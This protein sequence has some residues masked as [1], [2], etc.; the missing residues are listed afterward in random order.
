MRFGDIA[1]DGA[2]GAI[3]AH[4]LKAEGLR[5]KKGRV[6]SAEDVEA[7]RA[8]GVAYVTAAVLEPGDVAENAAA[9]RLGAAVARDGV[10]VSEA[11]TGRVNLFAARNG[12]F[13][14]DRA[15][16]DR[17]NRIHPAITFACLND[18]VQV[19]EGTMVATIKII[20]LAVAGAAVDAAL[21]AI[22]EPGLI[23]VKPFRAMRTALVSTTLPTLKASVMDKTVELLRQRLAPS[24]S[25]LTGEW[26]VP[27]ETE[28]VSEALGEA[29]RGSDMLIL[30]GASAVVDPDDVIPAAIRAAGGVVHQVG[31]P[32]DPGNLLVIGALRGLP[33]IG[34]PGCARSPKENGFDWVLA[35]VLAGEVPGAR[36]IMAMGVGG[37]LTEIPSRPQPRAG[38]KNGGNRPVETVLLAAGRAS[39]M[40]EDSGHKLLALFDGEPLVRRA[41]RAA[42]EAGVGRVHAVV[43]FR[44]EAITEALAGL[45]LDIVENPDFETGMAGSLAAGVEC[46][47]HEAAGALV[48]L[49]DMPGLSAGH[50]RKLAAAFRARH[51]RAIVRAA[52][53]GRRGNPVILPREAFAQVLKLS[54]DLGARAI[55]ESGQFEVVDVEIG[56]AAHLDVDTPEAIRS[57]GGRLETETTWDRADA[58]TQS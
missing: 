47:S 10:A 30:F 36:E 21:E 58:G 24:G 41:A 9:A 20:P 32:V 13:V 45:D 46:V 1:I 57:A 33:V 7:L 35:R 22:A 14:A 42:I 55:V 37:L 17:L 4:S 28:A 16:V 40:G 56:E 53:D 3:L 34:A 54:G 8:A 49:A 12:L 15:L 44:R 23:G 38:V 26:R 5:F 2:E 31:M 52:H 39:R 6:I 51:A 19:S 43:G 11:S 27:H 48:L 50:L 18:H 29:A 25:R